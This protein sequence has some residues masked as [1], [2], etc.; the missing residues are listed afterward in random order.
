MGRR[1]PAWQLARSSSSVAGR[2]TVVLIWTKYAITRQ[3]K[4]G[5]LKLA[6]RRDQSNFQLALSLFLLGEKKIAIGDLH[7][8]VIWLQ[9]LESST[10]SVCYVD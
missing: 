9:I 2:I 1:R 5:I 8:G 7:D 10:L 6:I 4:P 3:I